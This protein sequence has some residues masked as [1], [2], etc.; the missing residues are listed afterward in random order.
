MRILV[1]GTG[2][3]TES[4]LGISGIREEDIIGY[5]ESKRSKEVYR[6]KKVYMSGEVKGLDYDILIIASSY[7]EEIKQEM[8]KQGIEKKNAV[9]LALSKIGVL[10][11]ENITSTS[12]VYDFLG[13]ESSKTWIFI[14]GNGAFSNSKAFLE[15]RTTELNLAE[16]WKEKAVYA[17]SVE[18]SEIAKRQKAFLEKYFLPHLAKE[19]VICDFA[20][21]SGEWSEIV[22]PYVGHV[23][24]FDCSENMINVARKNAVSRKIDNISYDYM[25]AMQLH[26]ERKY[27]HFVMMGLLTYIED[28]QTMEQVVKSVAKSMKTGGFLVLR[29]TLNMS[30]P[31]KIYYHSLARENYIAVY[32]SKKLYENLFMN[33]GFE[34]VQEEYFLSYCDKPIEVGSHGYILR[35]V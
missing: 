31:D 2:N 11:E 34:I 7:T 24:G 17:P 28:G 10:A 16:Y 6:E 4:F 33:N 3:W 19:H 18:I 27:D 20:C 15:K 26:F 12:Q 29:D 32:H 1:W 8:E 21:A 14:G 13:Q 23:D 5:I 9:F 25:D 35:K 30:E 22:A